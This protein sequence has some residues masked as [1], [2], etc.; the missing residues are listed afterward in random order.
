MF[1]PTKKR[2]WLAGGLMAVWIMFIWGN[3]LLNGADSSAVS[4]FA[5]EFLALIL[6][7]WIEEATVLIRKLAH[8]TEF[9]V[10][11]F[12]LGWNSRLWQKGSM[13]AV[14]GGLLAALTDETIQSFIP[15]RASMVTDV[16]IDFVGVLCGVSVVYHL[17]REG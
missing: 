14:L 16:W 9:A 13:Y 6:G 15:G 10:L 12:L 17:S 4:G 3:S 5:G 1:R 2:R 7:S 8:L 11:G